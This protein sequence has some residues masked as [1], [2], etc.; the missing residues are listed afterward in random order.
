MHDNPPLSIDAFD[1]IKRKYNS[2]RLDFC[3]NLKSVAFNEIGYLS[4]TRG[5]IDKIK[6]CCKMNKYSFATSP[7]M[8][9]ICYLINM[10]GN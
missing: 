7:L 1:Y 5:K 2:T 10:L 4:M 9:E 6:E 3:E 8:T